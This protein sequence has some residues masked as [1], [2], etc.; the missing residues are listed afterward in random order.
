LL[1]LTILLCGVIVFLFLVLLLSILLKWNKARLITGILMSITSIIT[2]ILFI[3]IQISNGNP[4]AGME[5][6]QFYFPILVFLGFTT[7]GIFSTVKLAKW[8]INDVA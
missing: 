1:E 6:V 5:F 7:V 3:D 2:M 4:D 8:N